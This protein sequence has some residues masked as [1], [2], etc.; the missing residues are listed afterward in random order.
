[1]K[2][3]TL[4][5]IALLAISGLTLTGCNK[6]VAPTEEIVGMANPAAVYCEDQWG[7]LLPQQDEEG[8]QYAL[9]M[10]EDGSYCEERSYF[11][12]ECQQGEIFYNVIEDRVLP[13]WAK[14][15]LTNEELD[16]LTETNF[17]TSY[18]YSTYNIETEESN[19][20]EYTYPEDISH[21]LLLPIHATMAN[22]EIINSGIEDGMIYTLTNVTLQDDTVVS[23][24][25]IVDPVTLN[26]VAANVENGNEMTNYQF[27][28]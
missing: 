6:S 7:T 11:R 18:S 15:S 8:N 3:R 1:M 4:W 9:C 27:M 5:L 22:R 23:V 12:N 17:P 25:Y 14:T 2:I 26:F 28:Y 16:E 21:T 19:L 13:E 20:W 10:F 24:L